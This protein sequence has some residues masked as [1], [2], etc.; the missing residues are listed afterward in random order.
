[1]PDAAEIQNPEHTAST[2]GYRVA[3]RGIA[4][5][6][7][8]LHAV[9]SAFMVFG[10]LLVW[11]GLVPMWVHVPLAAWGVIVHLANWTCPLTPM[12]K[13]M[14]RA[15]GMPVYDTGFVEQY[16]MPR[17]VRG[18]VSSTGHVAVGLGLLVVNLA[19]YWLVL[20]S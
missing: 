16:L 6:L 8:A 14:R 17:A 5:G 18:R 11:R 3:Y 20:A 9:V 19:I 1:M 2:A 15:A 10:G 13:R 4:T 12:E 7:V